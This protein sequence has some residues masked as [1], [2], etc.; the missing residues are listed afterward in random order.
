MLFRGIVVVSSHLA[1]ALL[2]FFFFNDTATTEIYTLS[3]HDALPILSR[4]DLVGHALRFLG[5]FVQPPAHEALDREHRVLG[6]GDGLP[7]G[8]LTDEPLAILRE[9]DHGR[10]DPAAFGIGD[11]DGIAALH[12]RDYR[13]G[14]PEVDPDDFLS[15][16]ENSLS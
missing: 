15:H 12:H 10:R 5:H 8:D 14:R 4:Q 6:V 9:R 2:D 1:L 3:L 7:L 11:D 13:V 16:D